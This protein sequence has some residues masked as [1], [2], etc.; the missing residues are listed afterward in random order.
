MCVPLDG[1]TKLLRLQWGSVNS[2]IISQPWTEQGYLSQ[3]LLFLC[4]VCLPPYHRS[5]WPQA[6]MSM[7]N[8]V[9]GGVIAF[10]GSLVYLLLAKDSQL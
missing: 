9:P 10:Q 5:K 1:D 4:G 2:V 6:Y 3:A 7:R 8:T